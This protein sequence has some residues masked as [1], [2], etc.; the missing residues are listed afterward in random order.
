LLIILIAIWL[1]SSLF[2]A[3]C[4]EDKNK[5]REDEVKANIHIIQATIERYDTDH[6]HYPSFL[7]GGDSKGWRMWHL[8]HDEPNPPVDE[9]SDNLVQDVL[10]QYGYLES[11]PKNPFVD[12]G[13]NV[14][15]STCAKGSGPHGELEPGDGTLASVITVTSWEWTR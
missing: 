7:L 9:P 6:Q 5:V 13:M 11:Y 4:G 10:I 14:I 12:D 2:L 3:S 15:M 8:Y 1:F